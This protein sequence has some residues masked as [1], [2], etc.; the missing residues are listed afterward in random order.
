MRALALI[1]AGVVLPVA[2]VLADNPPT[3]ISW[4]KTVIDTKFRA[5]APPLPTSTATAKWTS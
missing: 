2:P 3:A 4:K 1:C 5:E